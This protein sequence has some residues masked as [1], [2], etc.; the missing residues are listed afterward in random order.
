MQF[1]ALEK[2]H[3]DDRWSFYMEKITFHNKSNTYNHNELL[4]PQALLSER[5]DVYITFYKL[6]SKD[7]EIGTFMFVGLGFL[8]QNEGLNSI[9]V[10]LIREILIFC[11]CDD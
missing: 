3:R 1:E 8:F 11:T 9:L 6:I 7:M 10:P 5:S 4:E 2:N